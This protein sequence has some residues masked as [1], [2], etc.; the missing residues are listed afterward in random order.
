MESK[1]QESTSTCPNYDEGNLPTEQSVTSPRLMKLQK[2]L[3]SGNTHVLQ[4][5]W[6]EIAVQGAPIIE[7]IDDDPEHL[8]VTFLWRAKE[9]T[10]N[11]VVV[12]N[13]SRYEFTDNQL[14]RLLDTD[15]WYRTYI[16]RNDVRTGYQL[17]L[18]D[19]L[20]PLE[21]EENFL[22]RIASWKPDP[23][24]PRIF[25]FPKDDEDPKDRELTDSILELPQAPPQ[26]WIAS[27]P[28][29]PKGQ[30]KMARF[31]SEI[32]INDRR[33]WIYTP[34]GYTPDGK[35][36]PLLILFDGR[37]Y[38]VFVPTPT[39]LDNLLAGDLIP[40]MVAVLVHNPDREARSRELPC[41]PPLVDFL[42]QE[43]K[44][45]IHQQCH[46][47]S[48]PA[49]TIIGGSSF[50]GLAATFAGLRHP[51]LFGNI[52]SQSGSFWWKPDEEVEGE[53]LSRQ[54]VAADKLPLRF[55]LDVGSLEDGPG[56]E[57][58]PNQLI[59]N[60]HLRDIL[61]AKGYPVHYAEYS[62]GH[63]YMCWQGTLADGLLAL[64]GKIKKQKN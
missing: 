26:P 35:P 41:Y 49:A 10:K 19:S 47:T 13:I 12:G 50:G 14:S 64:I 53:W 38:L 20:I 25:H 1:L 23:L 57:N 39:I 15:L 6:N 29:V 31:H 56:P 40:P 54:F 59:A 9:D 42:S 62:G 58:G 11:V 44:P 36:Y 45:W 21:E 37:A 61:R 33:I 2:E 63:D 24:N 5:F 52:L 4:D 48:D 28:G 8:R 22:E 51:E 16:L 17:G 27:H 3:E 55:Y 32:L 43:L 30:V 7:T 34:P 46:V 60:R 18:N